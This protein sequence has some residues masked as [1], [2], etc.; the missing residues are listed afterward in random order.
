MQ[1]FLETVRKASLP[2]VWSQG[3]KLAREKAVAL[4]GSG[5]GELT[6]RVRAPGHAVAPTVTLYVATREWSCDC[7]GQGRP[8][9]AR[10]GRGH[11]LGHGRREGRAARRRARRGEA[12]R[13]SSTA[14]GAR[15]ACSSCLAPSS[16][17]TG[18]KSGSASLS[19]PTG[20]AGQALAELTPTH[21]DMRI[22]R[23][24]GSPPRE[25][26]L[27]ARVG[28]VF[29]ALSAGAEVT[30]DGAPVTVSG[31]RVL[32]RAT[33][34]DAPGGG[35]RLRLERDPSILEVVA[36]GRRAV[37]R[38][39]AAARRDVDDGRAPRAPP[40]RADVRA[41]RH[42]R[43]RDQ[44]PPRARGEARRRHRDVAAPPQGADARPRIAMDLSHQGHTLSVLPTLVYGD[45]PV[46]RIDGDAMVPL[47]DTVPVR[48]HEH[49]RDLLRRLRDELHLVPGRRV[50]LDGSEAIRFATKL[51]EWQKRTGDDGAT[52]G[53][54]DRPPCA[55]ACL[56]GQRQLRRPLRV[57]PRTATTA[58]VPPKRA[59]AAAV[60]R[61]WRDGLELVPLEGGGWAPL[62]ADWLAKHGHLVAD[63]LA[64][65]GADKRLTPAA[66]PT[67]GALCDALEQPRPPALA[68]LAPLFEG[69]E[70]IPHAVLPEGL[71]ATLRSYQRQGV[72]WLSFLR[73]AGLGARPG[74]RHGP[75]Q[76]AADAL[77]PARA[78]AG[79]LP[80]ERRLQLGRRDRALPA[81]PA[82][83]HLPRAQ[84]RARPRRRR[85][86]DDLRPAPAR[87]AAPRAGRVGRR[88][89]RRGAGH[90]EPREPDGAR[91]LRA[92][93]EVPHR[94]QR[95]AGREPPRRALE[96]HALRQ[97][98][99]ARR[100]ER[101]PGAL[102][103][104]HRGGQPG[105]GRAAAREDP[106]VHPAAH[107]GR[108]GPG[109]A[110]PDRHRAPRRARRGRAQHL[111]RGA[112]RDQAGGRRP[113]GRTEAACSPPSRRCCVCARPRATRRSCPASTATSSS[114]VER[115]L[116]ALEESVAE[117]HKALV[118]SQW[119]SLLDLVEPAL[120]ARPGSRSPA[121][122][123]RPSIAAPWSA[124]SRTTRARR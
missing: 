57:R 18:A 76:D 48:R 13:G 10:H 67:A 95:H 100:R 25:I 86:A 2:G 46:A 85:D 44:G 31:E 92:A 112:R 24:L 98:G 61:A 29:E 56:D 81:G 106:P 114:K 47:G 39:P 5:E 122:T 15:T 42:R 97:P 104:P 27:G 117:G 82:H 8:L 83:G 20:R 55:R 58:K 35:F 1:Q 79:R 116:E 30:F 119:T 69:F 26:V 109:A 93:R 66:L 89:P 28:D 38:R 118:F 17:T 121:S 60:L 110:A 78:H 12:R 63:L 88:G 3:V 53:L 120:Q 34:S 54:R 73:D 4:A 22:D 105:G 62:P 90:Q 113:D 16:T 14:S 71:T 50:D 19:R 115:L 108:G 96:R 64:A 9:H 87:R 43:P 77:R 52:H 72:D 36:R 102:L 111:R 99:P 123:A 75:R 6:L 84:A 124:S 45:P 21:E 7:D 49:E 80:E 74:R 33:V 59:E 37:R 32:P 101:L 40:A 51:R 23:I 70:G 68:R 91:R 94:P 103:R 65:R 11:R 107:E 41:R